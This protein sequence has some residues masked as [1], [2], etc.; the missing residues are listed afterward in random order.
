MK[1]IAWNGWVTKIG[2][3]LSIGVLHRP[4]ILRGL[5]RTDGSRMSTKGFDSAG[6]GAGSCQT[7]GSLA[8]KG[9]PVKANISLM[10]MLSDPSSSNELNKVPRSSKRSSNFSTFRHKE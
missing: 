8:E 6:A 5:L 4:N 1:G 2:G 9:R 7:S 10:E 3:C